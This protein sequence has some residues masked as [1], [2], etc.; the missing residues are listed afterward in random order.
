[1]F[2]GAYTTLRIS[3]LKHSTLQF[4]NSCRSTLGTHVFVRKDVVNYFQLSWLSPCCCVYTA[5]FTQTLPLGRTTE[6]KKTK[7]FHQ[8]LLPPC[9][10]NTVLYTKNITLSTLYLHFQG[11]EYVAHKNKNLSS[12]KTRYAHKMFLF[13][14]VSHL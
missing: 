10:T 9:F 4:P 2:T 5:V 12:T 14:Q 1:M 3:N 11:L 6:K 7:I 13:R 8:I